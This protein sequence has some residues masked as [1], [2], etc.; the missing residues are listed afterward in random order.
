MIIAIAGKA[1]SGKSTLAQAIGYPVLSMAKEVK[2]LALDLGWNGV[3]DH[4]GRKLLQTLGTDLCRD[5]IDQDYWI[6]CW[7]RQY[8]GGDVIIDDVRFAN[9]L[10]YFTSIGARTVLITSRQEDGVR[11]HKSESVP[12]WDYDLVFD[13][14]KGYSALTEFA[15]LCRC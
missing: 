1:G 15:K 3:K 9:E 14:S 2:R 12:A 13:N 8:T 4:Q 10:E 6:E 11:V 7:K 5:C